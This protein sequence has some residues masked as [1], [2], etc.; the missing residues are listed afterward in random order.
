MLLSHLLQSLLPLVLGCV[1]TKCHF[2]STCVER[3]NG[4]AACL[5]NEKCALKFEPVCG[6]NGKTYINECLLRADACKQR[7]SFVVLQKGA[8]SKLCGS[9]CLWCGLNPFLYSFVAYSKAVILDIQVLR[10][11]Q[12]CWLLVIVIS[13]A[14]LSATEQICIN[15]HT[16]FG[17][18]AL[19]FIHGQF[20][21]RVDS[22]LLWTCPFFFFS[23]F[24]TSCGFWVFGSHYTE[25]SNSKVYVKLVPLF[26]NMTSRYS[27]KFSL[28]FIFNSFF[29]YFSPLVLGYN[30]MH[31]VEPLTF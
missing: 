18:V 3:P 6:S 10:L 11:W 22:I 2:Y 13:L 9:S 17:F 12:Q 24:L 16:L 4:Q 31:L 7:K 30:Q 23:L 15:W 14:W 29:S 20:W 27:A 1:E 25:V 5:C 19:L 21:T 28:A 26:V 8:C